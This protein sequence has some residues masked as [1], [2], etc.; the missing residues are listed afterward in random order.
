MVA[1]AIII[2]VA[3]GLLAWQVIRTA[4]V[5]SGSA[6]ETIGARLWASHPAVMTDQA[7]A[8]IGARAARG[9][10]ASGGTLRRVE[11]ISEKAPLAPEPFLIKGAVAQ[12]Q[13]HQELAEQLFTAARSRDPR[14][15]AARYFLAERYLRTDRIEPAL[16]E[17]GALSRLM[18]SADIFSPALAQY[19][20]RP[21]AVP[22]L[23]RFFHAS[24]EFE[25]NV[26]SNLSMDPA[27][28][29]LIL[30]LWSG[31]TEP[32]GPGHSSPEWQTRILAQLVV[33]GDF[34]RA[35]LAWRRFAGVE[36]ANGGLFNPRFRYLAAPA[37]F[38]WTFGSGG[39]LAQ[40]APNGQLE[41]IYF[42]SD[43]AV[44]AKQ[45]LLLAPGPYRL[46][47]EV[48]GDLDEANDIAWSIECFSQN[49]PLMR[50]RLGQHSSS[51]RLEANFTVPGGCPAQML[52]LSGFPGEFRKTTEFTVG[53]L[54]LTRMRAT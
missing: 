19:A 35:Y 42:G 23:R 9:E 27:N 34:K 2:A 49:Q 45:L 20:H 10:P 15:L 50:L 52:K 17:M 47:M 44:L 38:N 39:G 11:E 30:N 16:G 3:G 6:R 13:Q 12:V 41:I 8:E 46:S 53:N 29:E 33:K 14:S 25:R 54:Q 37:P 51:A 48:K 43:D 7:M 32:A 31:G 21:G 22:Q 28:L 26:L 4:V 1:R 5:E 24:P 36:Q 40:P 18:H